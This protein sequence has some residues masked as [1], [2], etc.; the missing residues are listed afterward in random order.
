MKIQFVFNVYFSSFIF[1]LNL[2]LCL[3]FQRFLCGGRLI[4][5][6]D[7]ASLCFSMLLVAGPAVSFCIKVYNI[8]HYNKEHNRDFGYWYGVLIVAA[9]LTC[10][11]S[12]SL[13]DYNI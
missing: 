1:K 4:F 10:L 3:M 2:H 5:G 8:I 13:L 11:V 6:P 7:V 9:A 12:K